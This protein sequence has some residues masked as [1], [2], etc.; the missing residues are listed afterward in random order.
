MTGSTLFALLFCLVYRWFLGVT[1]TVGALDGNTPRQGSVWTD[2]TERSLREAIQEIPFL[3]ESTIGPTFRS[4]EGFLSVASRLLSIPTFSRVFKV[5]PIHFH[6]S[7]PDGAVILTNTE[8]GPAKRSH[9][10]EAK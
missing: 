5:E 8:L 6:A 3:K 4:Q 1:S 9:E 10:N 2:K 7:F